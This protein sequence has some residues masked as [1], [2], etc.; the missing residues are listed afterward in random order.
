MRLALLVAA[1]AAVKVSSFGWNAEDSTEF[2]QRAL[3]SGASRVVLDR[4][5]GDWISRPLAITNSD[6]EVVIEDGVTLRAKR[7]AFYGRNDC[8]VRISGGIGR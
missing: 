7:G 3:D 6:I 4:Q 5:A 2:L 8:L 1:A